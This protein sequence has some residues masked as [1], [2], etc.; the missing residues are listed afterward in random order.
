MERREFI[1]LAGIG[2]A[3][4]VIPIDFQFK[5]RYNGKCQAHNK[6]CDGKDS[7]PLTNKRFS[8]IS[9]GPVLCAYHGALISKL[10]LLSLR[11]LE[12][13]SKKVKYK[14]VVKDTVGLITVS[15]PNRRIKTNIH[16]D[17]SN[18]KLSYFC[19]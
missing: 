9:Q 8:N 6:Y 18:E 19:W 14:A 3:A 2:S 11:Q 7:R 15:S 13:L 10:S 1:K 5:K 17:K 4:L 12:D 16:K